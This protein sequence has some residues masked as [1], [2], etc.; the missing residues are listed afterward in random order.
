MPRSM[1][2]M[3]SHVLLLQTSA[4]AASFC[5]RHRRTNFLPTVRDTRPAPTSSMPWTLSMIA[6]PAEWTFQSGGMSTTRVNWD[7]NYSAQIANI[8]STPRRL[9]GPRRSVAGMT[10]ALLPIWNARNVPRQL[11]SQNGLVHRSVSATWHSNFMNGSS[12]KNSWITYPNCSTI[13]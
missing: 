2:R 5:R 11:H 4:I 3:I 8:D 13:R 12:S 6:F 10:L 7:S 9:I 1:K